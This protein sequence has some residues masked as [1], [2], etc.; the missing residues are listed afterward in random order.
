M[1]FKSHPRITRAGAAFQAAEERAHGISGM[2]PDYLCTLASQK[3]LQYWT[4]I[5]HQASCIILPVFFFDNQELLA[6]STSNLFLPQ[7][8]KSLRKMIANINV[9]LED[10]KKSATASS[11][12]KIV[13]NSFK[14]ICFAQMKII[15]VLQRPSLSLC[16]NPC[17]F[18]ASKNVPQDI[19]RRLTFF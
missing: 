19:K 2:D 3:A 10:K 16:S 9:K 14:K 6:I 4:E 5:Y 7:A 12:H 18:L 8:L 17:H 13:S 11:K 15:T 1:Q